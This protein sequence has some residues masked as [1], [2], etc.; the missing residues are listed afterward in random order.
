MAAYH[1]HTMMPL[2]NLSAALTQFEPDFNLAPTSDKTLTQ[3]QDRQESLLT[4]MRQEVSDCIV[5][6]NRNDLK[7]WAQVDACATTK[8]Q[9]QLQP[10]QPSATTSAPSRALRA[11]KL[12]PATLTADWTGL[13]L[14]PLLDHLKDSTSITMSSS[15]VAHYPQLSTQL[16]LLCQC[17][18]NTTMLT[19]TSTH[20]H[21]QEIFNYPR[22]M[23]QPRPAAMP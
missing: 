10:T 7:N 21:D 23:G 4:S 20:S 3:P 19:K 16:H 6:P 22:S 14:K 1:T 13:V 2:S 8:W 15:M 9:L 17:R 5:T 18:S 12:L 11:E